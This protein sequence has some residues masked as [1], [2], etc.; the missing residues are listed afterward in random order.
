MAPPKYLYLALSPFNNLY[1]VGGA[2]TIPPSLRQ[3][4]PTNLLIFVVVDNNSLYLK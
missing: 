2:I 3:S 1:F 4:I